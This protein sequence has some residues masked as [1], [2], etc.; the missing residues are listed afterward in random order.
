MQERDLH[1]LLKY[2]LLDL[3]LP[4]ISD[5]ISKLRSNQANKLQVLITE[6]QLLVSI[7]H[8]NDTN[9]LS[10]VVYHRHD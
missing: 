5:E 10:L 8:L 9:D 6:R 3:T 7:C 1:L 2:S 4:S